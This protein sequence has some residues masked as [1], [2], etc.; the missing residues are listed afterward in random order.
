MNPLAKIPRALIYKDLDRSL[1]Q[2]HQPSHNNTRARL[3]NPT[4]Y[5][6][7][8]SASNKIHGTIPPVCWHR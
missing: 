7:E 2:K 4:R 1:L 5:D 6:N 3:A 8:S